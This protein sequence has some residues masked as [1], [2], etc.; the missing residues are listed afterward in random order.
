MNGVRCWNQR[1]FRPCV[2]RETGW[3]DCQHGASPRE[4]KEWFEV[5]G[6]QHLFIVLAGN[7]NFGAKHPVYL[8][9]VPR[10]S[11]RVSV[12][13]KDS[14]ALFSAHAWKTTFLFAVRMI[15]NPISPHLFPLRNESPR[16]TVNGW[17]TL[18]ASICTRSHDRIG[19][20]NPLFVDM[21]SGV[22]GVMQSLGG[23]DSSA[24]RLQSNL[25]EPDEWDNADT[26]HAPLSNTCDESETLVGDALAC[27]VLL[28]AGSDAFKRLKNAM[29][30]LSCLRIVWRSAS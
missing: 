21:D 28:P 30:S 26:Q 2:F 15:P 14:T 13:R 16:S 19:W 29:P 7:S 22:G 6:M 10:T 17:K 27:G 20:S 8:G 9:R 5:P 24:V 4:A 1:K 23:L 12:S 25:D 11:S 18:T 3:R